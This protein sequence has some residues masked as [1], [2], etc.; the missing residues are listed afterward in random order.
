VVG[1]FSLA[2]P[3]FLFGML[4]GAVTTWCVQRTL[5]CPFSSIGVILRAWVYGSGMGD[6]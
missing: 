4:G 6:L 3:S 5:R 2:G 1:S